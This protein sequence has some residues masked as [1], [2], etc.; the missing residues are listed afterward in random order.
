MVGSQGVEEGVSRSLDVVVSEL[1]LVLP[2]ICE[3]GEGS[4]TS[5]E[6]LR[7]VAMAIQELAVRCC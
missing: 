7:R 6:V 4:G 5:M 3:G 2:F 1:G